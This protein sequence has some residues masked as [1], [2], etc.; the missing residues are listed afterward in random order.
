[1]PKNVIGDVSARKGRRS[2]S[3]SYFL[4]WSSAGAKGRKVAAPDLKWLVLPS[5]YIARVQPIFFSVTK[6]KQRHLNESKQSMQINLGKISVKVI[7]EI[8]KLK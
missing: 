8:R 6:R 5:E 4:S 2:S 7:Q 3:S 1:M